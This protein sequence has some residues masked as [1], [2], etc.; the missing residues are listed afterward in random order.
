MR[1]F[2]LAS[3]AVSLD[4]C[5][6]D[7]GPDRLVLSG[8]ADLDR[9]DEV[10]AGVDAILVGAGTVRADDPRLEVRSPGAATPLKVV[11]STGGPL[12]PAARVFAG[13]PV[14]VYC[15]GGAVP[16]AVPAEVVSVPDLPAVLADLAGRG[17][18]RLLVEG[19]TTVHTLFLTAGLV[20]ELH[21]AVA[22]ILV[23][24]ADAPRFVSPGVFPPGRM[25]LLGARPVGDVVL[26]R[27]RP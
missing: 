23:G 16:P 17:V 9:V 14:V 1:P 4:G 8:V 7:A 12:D 19:G 24:D 15:T 6:D 22:P 26:L 18:A 21:V 13:G 2:V 3:V 10:R 5:I 20:D 27:Y 25:T 11:L